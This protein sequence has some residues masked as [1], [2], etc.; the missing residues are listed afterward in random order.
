MDENVDLTL[1]SFSVCIEC[2]CTV[3]G[4]HPCQPQEGKPS[5]LAKIV[6]MINRWELIR[7]KAEAK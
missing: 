2:G 5:A 7:Q 6:F 3:M 4:P 1:D